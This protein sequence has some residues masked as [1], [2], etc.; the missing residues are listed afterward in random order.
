LFS[1]FL[2]LMAT[3]PLVTGETSTAYPMGGVA[4]TSH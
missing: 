2:V 1:F 3:S 4:G